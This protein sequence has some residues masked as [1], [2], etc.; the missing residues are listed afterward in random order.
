MSNPALVYLSGLN[1]GSR[2]TM[3]QAL[4][5]MAS[6]V[7]PESD[8][9]TFEW[10]GL[11]FEQTQ[12]VRAAL[13]DA[14]SPS[15]ARKMLSALR[16]VLKHAWRL[17]LLSGDDYQRAVDLAPVRGNS[18]AP[19]AGRAL[20]PIE[21]NALFAACTETRNRAARDAAILALFYAAGLRRTEMARL[22]L[23]SLDLRN[24]TLTVE[25]KGRKQRSVPLEDPAALKALRAWLA[26]RGTEAGPLFV[27]VLKSDRLIYARLASSAMSY[28]L[29]RRAAAAG[30]DHFSPHDLRRTFASDLLDAGADLVT[31]QKLMG[32]ASPTTT[33]GYDR[34]GEQ[35][36]RRA[37]RLIK[38]P[39]K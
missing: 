1:E 13:Q 2:R 4:D 38:T 8:H 31:V 14:Y 12:A 30:V 37:V 18:A 15:T 34:R 7:Q 23:D 17:G 29:S 9:I 33:A 16:S 35:A 28:I 27:R 20:A 19:T 24:K 36:K 22:D 26:V 11:R 25:G 39:Y 21:Y 10:G 6:L 32:H 5:V 3:Q